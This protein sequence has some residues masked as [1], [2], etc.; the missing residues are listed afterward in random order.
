MRTATEAAQRQGLKFARLGPFL[1]HNNRILDVAC[2]C[3]RMY[4]GIDQADEPDQQEA[5]ADHEAEGGLACK[6]CRNH[7]VSVW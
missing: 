1:F 4:Y 7:S 5:E 3:I 6:L 2:V